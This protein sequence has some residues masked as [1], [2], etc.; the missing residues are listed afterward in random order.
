MVIGPQKTSLIAFGLLA[1]CGPLVAYASLIESADFFAW[2]LVAFVGASFTLWQLGRTLVRRAV[3]Y[4]L[5]I[6]MIIGLAG[7][8]V[9]RHA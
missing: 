2:G 5:W 4:A 9:R 1:C 7:F 3:I 8:F 6:P